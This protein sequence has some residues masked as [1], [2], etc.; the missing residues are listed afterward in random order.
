MHEESLLTIVYLIL[1]GGFGALVQDIMKDGSLKLPK[2]K[3]GELILGFLGSI[4]I[5]ATVGF[6]V[7]HSPL[8]AFFAG[9]TGFAT[10]K[11]LVNTN[12]E[13]KSNGSNK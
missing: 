8:M 7:D 11:K 12:I 9:Y 3:N 1:S 5:G 6:L 10:L 4:I 13:L 2:I